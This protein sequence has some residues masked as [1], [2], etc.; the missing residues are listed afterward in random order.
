MKLRS[1][2]LVSAS[3]KL[4]LLAAIFSENSILDDIDRFLPAF[5]SSTDQ[6]QRSFYVTHMK[7]MKVIAV[8][9]YSTPNCIPV[10]FLEDLIF[11][12]Y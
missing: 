6:K 11:Q 5:F 1:L 8:L 3:D 10:V 7:V 9:D 2:I 12:L 4:K